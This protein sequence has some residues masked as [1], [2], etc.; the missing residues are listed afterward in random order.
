MSRFDPV[1][2]LAATALLLAGG[3]FLYWLSE[4]GPD[5]VEESHAAAPSGADE[6][7]DA[8]ARA[9]SRRGWV[10]EGA[11][12]A[13]SRADAPRDQ[14]A[15]SPSCDPSGSLVDLA[16]GAAAAFD[17][18]LRR[19][20]ALSDASEADIGDRLERAAGSSEVFS[21]RWDLASDRSRHAPYLQALVDHISRGSRRQ[22]VRWRVHVVRD[23]GFNAF[24]MAGG[25]LAV[26]TG[27]LE[28]PSA[29]SDEAELAA[30][31]GHEIAHV[32]LRHA[33][34]AYQYA[35]ALFGD[36]ADDAFILGKLFTLPISTALEHEADARGIELAALAG[37]DPF[38]ASRLWL[39]HARHDAPR[40]GGGSLSGALGDLVGL[41]EQVL[42]SHP[43]SHQRC[44]RSRDV[45]KRLN[46]A[47]PVARWYRGASNLKER[48][49][50]PRSPR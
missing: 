6:S 41:A 8:S 46:D 1:P 47:S 26:T 17:A 48:V 50:G 14:P 31:L 30:V 2:W 15:D 18:E 9:T 12:E 3:L 4:D 29:V 42:H 25:V 16:K 5:G 22:G 32:E 33:A 34:A 36:D 35:R 27:V 13:V 39:R 44:G 24:A 11:R 7:S 37:Y 43:P 10:P 45:A 40:H 38:A 23:D 20:T 21:G 49:P 19:A 28:G